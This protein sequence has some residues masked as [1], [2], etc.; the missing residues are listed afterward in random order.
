[1]SADPRVAAHYQMVLDHIQ[2]AQNELG[3]AAQLLS[4][5]NHGGAVDWRRV[6]R[7]YDQIHKLWYRVAARRPKL[8]RER[9]DGGHG[10]QYPCEACKMTE[11]GT[12]RASQ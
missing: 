11:T 5:I 2:D 9:L 4:T 12:A 6:N 7:A 10:E 1:M 3:R 8:R